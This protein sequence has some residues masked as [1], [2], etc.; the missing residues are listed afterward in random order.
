M[1]IKKKYVAAKDFAEFR[2]PRSLALSP[3]GKLL[4]YT[5]QWCDF[6]KKKYFANL[7]V[8]DLRTKQPRQWTFGEHSDRSPVWSGDGAK[9]AFLRAEKGEDKIYVISR[10]GGAPECVFHAR[11]SI[12]AIKW[13]KQD[14][15]ILARFRKADRDEDAEK[16]I[17]ERKEPPSSAPAAR[18]VTRLFYRLDGDGYFPE[19]PHHFFLVDLKNNSV[20]QLTR[21]KVE[22]EAPFDVSADGNTVAFVMNA[23]RELDLHPYH[24]QIY[25]LNL[26]TGARKSLDV[27]YGEKDAVAFS[28]NGKYLAYIGHH[29]IHDAWG[30]EPLH[31][32]LVDLKSGKVR[33]LTPKFDR[34]ACDLTIGDLGFGLGQPQL[35]FSRDSK[36]LYYQIS[37]EG[38][39]YVGRI[40]LNGGTPK[41][42]W[43]AAGQVGL[44]DVQ[45]HGMAVIHAGWQ[46]LGSIHYCA[47]IGAPRPA[48]RELMRFNE[49]YV[50]SHQ[51]GKVR[52]LGFKSGD[53]T[54]LHGWIVTPPDF[55]TGKKYPAIIEIHGGPRTQ[56]GRVFFHEMQYLAAR[57]YV[58]M[59]TNPRGSQGYGKDFADA[60]TARWGTVDYDDLVAAADMLEKQPYVDKKRIGVTGGS[61]GGYLTNIAIGKTQRFKAAVTQRS[62]VDL[63]SFFG[64]SDIG[65]LD[66]YEFGG[67]EWE[68]PENYQRMSPI[69]YVDSMH[70]PLL[71]VH[72]EGDLR[73]PIEQAE[74]LY[75]QLKVRR[76]TVE[77]LRFPEEFHGLSRGGRPDRRV[78]RLEAI[79]EWFDRWMKR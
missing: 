74:Q 12:A 6:D 32:F 76:R 78:I 48:F 58:V 22:I 24:L 51:L 50:Q 73:C 17:K 46:T 62:V 65:Y 18:R 2:L 69:S 5:E 29:N 53:G 37:S 61:Y 4:A 30:V 27:A 71:I 68:N 66:H 21:G 11:G 15:A 9:L 26:K 10:E 47:N 28:P 19:E 3:D 56:Y 64:T 1:I 79:A 52:E 33:D 23:H 14:Q 49:E 13:A 34:Q 72:N 40:G 60:I 42:V 55:K 16:A 44:M 36:S 35:I 20:T 67:Y 77:F 43:S 75:A 41:R 38:D 57:G 7:H 8:L 39:T 54:R 31:P 25:L 59:F 45:D 63:H 70:T